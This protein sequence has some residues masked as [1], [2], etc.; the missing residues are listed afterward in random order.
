MRRRSIAHTATRTVRILS[1]PIFLLCMLCITRTAVTGAPDVF[2]IGRGDRWWC[3]TRVQATDV[4]ATLQI[5]E[6]G[7]AP[8]SA[9]WGTGPFYVHTVGEVMWGLFTSRSP[10]SITAH[11]WWLVGWR[12]HQEGPKLTERDYWFDLPYAPWVLLI[13]SG[14]I[15]L[16]WRRQLLKV[17]RWRRAGLCPTCSYD[18]RAH[19]PNSNCPE[20][21]TPIPA[22]HSAIIPN[23]KRSDQ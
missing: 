11:S 8:Y 21:G 2:N 12:E 17:R 18:L 3:V 10:V 4:A 20:C 9:G 15:L 19:S 23:D 7:Y 5:F 14:A 16:V 1:V 6:R 13:L 22:T